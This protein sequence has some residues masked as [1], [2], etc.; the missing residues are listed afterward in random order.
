M[1]LPINCIFCA[2]LKYL[3]MISPSEEAAQKHPKNVD[4]GLIPSWRKYVPRKTQQPKTTSESTPLTSRADSRASN[5]HSR[6]S[7]TAS[8]ATIDDD[9]EANTQDGKDPEPQEIFDQD[10]DENTLKVAR[11]AKGNKVQAGTRGKYRRTTSVCVIMS[12][13]YLS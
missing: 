1:R 13:T 8:Y 2:D 7:S 9:N 12:S 5:Q 6:A 11:A 10:E 4:D 3:E